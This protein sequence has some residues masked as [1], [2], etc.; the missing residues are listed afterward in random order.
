MDNPIDPSRLLNAK[1][2][3]KIYNDAVSPAAREAG[4]VGEDLVKSFRLFTAPIQL[5][6]AWQDRFRMWLDDVRSRVPTSR[7]VEAPAHIAG[8]VL[9]NLRFIED[10]NLLRRLY[11]ELLTRSIDCES[12]HLVHPAFVKLLEQM[13]QEE[14]ILLYY[15]YRGGSVSAH[16]RDPEDSRDWYEK[17]LLEGLPGLSRYPNVLRGLYQHINHLEL[18]GLIKYSTE[19]DSYDDGVG[20]AYVDYGVSLYLTSFGDRFTEVCVPKDLGASEEVLGSE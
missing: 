3:E 16:E 20:T 7:Q 12:H 14:A 17:R 15:L 4:C 6:A 1:V 5:L 8:P 9:L 10:D 18:L 13:S 11:L 2:T 19:H